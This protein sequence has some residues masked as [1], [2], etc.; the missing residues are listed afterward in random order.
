MQITMRI[1][2]SEVLI[3]KKNYVNNCVH[4]NKTFDIYIMKAIRGC[5]SH[6]IKVHFMPCL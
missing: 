4:F 6:S 1:T 3:D 2:R 5:K